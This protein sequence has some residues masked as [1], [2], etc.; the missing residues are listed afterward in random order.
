VINNQQSSS[1][2]NYAISHYKRTTHRGL[3]HSHQRL[4][5]C[6]SPPHIK[7]IKDINT[8]TNPSSNKYRTTS[9]H[10][11]VH[12]STLPLP[13]SHPEYERPIAHANST[14]TAPMRST[15]NATD[16]PLPYSPGSSKR[17]QLTTRGARSCRCR[18]HE[19]DMRRSV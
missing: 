11:C 4:H 17:S 7:R 18:K 12:T 19:L 10:T 13:R 14:S 5:L 1:T 8:L 15:H 9:Y 3:P 2:Q 16:S 6:T